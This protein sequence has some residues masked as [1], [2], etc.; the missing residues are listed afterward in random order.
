MTYTLRAKRGRAVAQAVSRWLPT[1]AARV[2]SRS[3]HVGFVVEKAAL[4]QV[5]SGYFGFPCQSSFTNFSLIIIS[6]GWHNKPI[7]GLSG[8]WTQLDPPP[9]IPIKKKLILGKVSSQTIRMWRRQEKWSSF[10]RFFLPSVVPVSILLF[11]LFRSFSFPFFIH[12]LVISSPLLG[13]F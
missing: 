1:A 2:R 6:R 13:A 3:E 4:G 12:S 5:F 7:G 8:E 10:I 9:S 11:T